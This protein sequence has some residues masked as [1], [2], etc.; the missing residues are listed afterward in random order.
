[1]KRASRGNGIPRRIASTN[2]MISSPAPRPT[3]VAP[4]ILPFDRVTTLQKP[5]VAL[6]PSTIAR[7]SSAKS[8]RNTWGRS[9]AAAASSTVIPTRATSG[10]V[11]VTQGTTR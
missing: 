4:R 11:N 10:S 1:M 6:P 9:P 2:S 8:E 7:S 5:V 3:I